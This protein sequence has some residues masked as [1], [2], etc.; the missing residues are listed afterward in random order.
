MAKISLKPRGVSKELAARQARTVKVI[1]A[2]LRE[3]AHFGRTM[4][5]QAVDQAGKVDQGQY[6][7]SFRV[8]QGKASGQFQGWDMLAD[9]PHAGIIEGGARPHPVSPEGIDSIAQWARRKLGLSEE[10]AHQAAIAIAWKL[11]HKGQEGTFIIRDLVPALG[12]ALRHI[13]E[14]KLRRSSGRPAGGP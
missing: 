11:R 4:A 2:A 14:T 12:R 7:N 10:E 3:A 5:V 6:R 1:N 8:I 13:A 9:A